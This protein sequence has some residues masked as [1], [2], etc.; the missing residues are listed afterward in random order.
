MGCEWS[1]LRSGRFTYWYRN[2]VPIEYGAGYDP[3]TA[4]TFWRRQKSLCP[5]EDEVLNF[6]SLISHSIRTERHGEKHLVRESVAG[7]VGG[8]GGFR[9][10]KQPTEK[11]RHKKT[12]IAH[13][14]NKKYDALEP[15]PTKRT[16]TMTSFEHITRGKQ[17]ASVFRKCQLLG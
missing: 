16:Y 8:G 1:N 12:Y 10:Q 5:L 15:C 14:Q 3:G 9:E 11:F 7:R 13:A 4:R 6:R 2:T 17:I